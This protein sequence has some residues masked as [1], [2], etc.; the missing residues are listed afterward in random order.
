MVFFLPWPGPP[1]SCPLP[2]GTRR[3]EHLQMW[4][5]ARPNQLQLAVIQLQVACWRTL[6]DARDVLAAWMHYCWFN[7]GGAGPIDAFGYYYFT[8]QLELQVG[9]PNFSNKGVNKIWTFCVT[10][11]SKL[12]STVLK[13]LGQPLSSAVGSPISR[14]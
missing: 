14:N 5:T 8:R 2:G 6:D 9:S 7:V 11:T 1:F 3:S 10:E 13:Y 12:M 4:Q